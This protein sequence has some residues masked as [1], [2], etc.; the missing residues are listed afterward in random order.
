MATHIIVPIDGSAASWRG[1]DVAIALARRFDAKVEVVQVESDSVDADL[2]REQ[3][4]VDIDRRVPMDVPVTTNV[5]LSARSVGETIS[6]LVEL[7]PDV[8]VVMASH[9]KGR[10]AA[11][12]G[13]VADQILRHS[14]GPIVLVGPQAE[15]DDFCGPLVITVDGSEASEAAVPLGVA[16]A[17]ELGTTP[18][19][20]H[21]TGSS[22]P[23]DGG[24]GDR[25]R[26][27]RP[28]GQRATRGVRPL[29]RVRRVARWAPGR[30]GVRLRAATPC[31][32]DRCVVPRAQRSVPP[33]DGQRHIRFRSPRAVPRARLPPPAPAPGV[34][35]VIT[36][37]TTTRPAGG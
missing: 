33:D 27:P 4:A 18:W 14:F 36:G 17:V 31:V 20:V 30:C 10:S 21:A 23:G 15:P 12:V 8:L 13:S 32:A 26:L 11:V 37:P 29:G 1:F 9:G 25:R 5:Q 7:V 22:P 6:A 35:F 28:T 19:I 34:D 24:D 3:L 16:W 2:A